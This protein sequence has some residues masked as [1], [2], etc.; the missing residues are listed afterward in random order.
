[1]GVILGETFVVVSLIWGYKLSNN[2]NYKKIIFQVYLLH[3]H[4]K[5]I[6]INEYKNIVKLW[7]YIQIEMSVP[8][9]HDSPWAVLLYL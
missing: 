4:C 6:Q 1:M 9:K 3:L 2:E 5:S 7:E 8:G